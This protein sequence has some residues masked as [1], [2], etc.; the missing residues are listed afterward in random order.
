MFQPE[1]LSQD[2]CWKITGFIQKSVFNK[3]RFVSAHYNMD[4][5]SFL[6]KEL[7]S[8]ASITCFSLVKPRF[9]SDA[10]TASL[11]I[12]AGEIPRDWFIR[13]EPSNRSPSPLFPQQHFHHSENWTTQGALMDGN[14]EP[15]AVLSWGLGWLVR[16]R[17]VRVGVEG[18]FSL[19]FLHS[20]QVREANTNLFHEPCA[21]RQGH[22]QPGRHSEPRC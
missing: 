6:N 7:E 1:N 17:E 22:E 21:V 14:P 19:A 10:I 12:K 11:E 13:I 15:W 9:Y 20:E 3:G 16:W 2:R 5:F 4:L 8:V 18:R